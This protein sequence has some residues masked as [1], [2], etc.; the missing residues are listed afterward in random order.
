MTR[1][2][3]VKVIELLMKNPFL[4]ISGITFV[5]LIFWGSLSIPKALWA[6]SPIRTFLK[7]NRLEEALPYCRQIV[8]LST[9]SSDDYAACAWVYFRTDRID[10]GQLMKAKLKGRNAT[11]YQ[12]LSAFSYLKKKKFTLARTA[13]NAL[14]MQFKGTSIGTTVEVLQ[15][16]L[17]E[18]RGD[19]S[20]AAFIYKQVV[21]KDPNRT[22]AHWGL[23]RHYL[24]RGE[25]QRAIL[26][27]N[28]TADG[29]PKHIA[30]RYNLG[31]LYLSDGELKKAGN[32]LAECYKLNAADAGVL[33]QLGILF[34]KKGQLGDAVKF[35]QK[36]YDVNKSSA[37]A[38]NKL[39]KYYG[40]L[41]E[42]ATRK[43][44]WG[45]VFKYLAAMEKIGAKHKKI[46]LWRGI[47]LRYE[48]KYAEAASELKALLAANPNDAQ[49]LRELGICY[50]NL[51]LLDDAKIAFK[52]AIKREPKNGANYSWLGYVFFSQGKNCDALA[53]FRKASNFTTDVDTQKK[54]IR[55]IASIQCNK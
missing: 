9:R 51:R 49:A 36:A 23:A 48:G 29:W 54:I 11:E 50:V 45:K 37:L 14:E 4:P 44:N 27:L 10:S 41:V 52:K 40:K 31:V 32:R 26:H 5:L 22:R 55:R 25:R 39:R 2:T 34:E 53:Y 6:I 12:L 42:Q 16:E 8:E 33:E 3:F 13:L 43:K 1:S 21:G 7:Q 47:A 30:S 35:W 20:T 17:F 18:A 15:A 24:N 19:T 28:E 38:K 46:H